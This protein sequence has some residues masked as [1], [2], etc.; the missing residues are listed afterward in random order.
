MLVVTGAPLVASP[1]SFA[2]AAYMALIPMFAGYFLFGFGLARVR[3]S[4]ATTLTLAEPAVAAV[5]A[6]LV[7]GERLSVL[8][9]AGLSVI[10][11]ALV[12][13][14]FAPA[15]VEAEGRAALVPPAVRA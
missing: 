6:V 8:G 7:V 5:L 13:L 2:V 3:P 15:N 10:G 11:A 4:T 9:W 1:P 12:V 14:A